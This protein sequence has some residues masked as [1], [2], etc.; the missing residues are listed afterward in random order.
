MFHVYCTRMFSDHGDWTAVW[1]SDRWIEWAIDRA[2]NRTVDRGIAGT[3][4]H[5]GTWTNEDSLPYWSLKW[6]LVTRGERGGPDFT[7]F[8]EHSSCRSP[9]DTPTTG[10]DKIIKGLRRY[11]RPL[12]TPERLRGFRIQIHDFNFY[13]YCN[14]TWRAS[15]VIDGSSA[16]T[17]DRTS[18]WVKK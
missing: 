1:S 18:D 17:S 8:T 10:I 12:L 13:W 6:S 4:A 9:L 5:D 2:K 7:K 15:R 3:E 16:R 11:R 14:S